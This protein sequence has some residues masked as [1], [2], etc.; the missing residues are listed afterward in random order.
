[1]AKV[2]AVVILDDNGQCVKHR[3]DIKRNDTAANLAVSWAA[4]GEGS[5]YVEVY[6]DTDG[7]AMYYNQD[8]G[9][10]LSGQPWEGR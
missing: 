8:D 10:S 1:M 3:G 5:V 4:L 9:Y 2:H 7:Q 6:R